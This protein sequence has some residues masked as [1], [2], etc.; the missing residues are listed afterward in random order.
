MTLHNDVPAV[1]ML[2]DGTVFEGSSCGSAG[3]AFGEIVFNTSMSGYQE[4]LS[5]PMPGRSSR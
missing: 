3:E 2:E 5:D 4:I 1:L